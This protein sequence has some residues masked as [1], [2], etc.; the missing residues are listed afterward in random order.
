MSWLQE[1]A[2]GIEPV[3][4]GAISGAIEHTTGVPFSGKLLDPENAR[5]TPADAQKAHNALDIDNDGDIDFDDLGEAISEIGHAVA[6]F[7]NSF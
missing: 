7:F 5:Y 6:D 1:I 4:N 3:V 2:K